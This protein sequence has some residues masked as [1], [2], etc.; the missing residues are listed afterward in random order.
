MNFKNDKY[1]FKAY[2]FI[3]L[4]ALFNIKLHGSLTTIYLHKAQPVAEHLALLGFIL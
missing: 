1:Y 4:C 2:S 3:F